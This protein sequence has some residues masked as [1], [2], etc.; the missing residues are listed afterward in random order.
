MIGE[1]V[2]RILSTIIPD[3]YLY[4]AKGNLF[5]PASRAVYEPIKIA[6]ENFEKKLHQVQMKDVRP[7]DVTNKC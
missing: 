1:C 7:R 2:H 3:L 6:E 4:A 5:H